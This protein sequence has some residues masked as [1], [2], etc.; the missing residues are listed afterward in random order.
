MD[1]GRNDDAPVRCTVEHLVLEGGVVCMKEVK[2]D[3]GKFLPPL[4][5]IP[6]E[7]A[8]EFVART[9]VDDM[10]GHL[11]PAKLWDRIRKSV[12]V[13]ECESLSKLVVLNC[14]KCMQAKDCFKSTAEAPL[15]KGNIP[16]S[17]FDHWH[18]DLWSCNAVEK[19]DK[20]FGNFQRLY[21]K[22]IWLLF[23]HVST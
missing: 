8:F 15:Q 16:T 11:Q 6:R 2:G 18:L 13:P 17:I 19:D 23:S 20:G 12:Y 5:V 21:Q 4:P 7:D 3:D 22:S 14:G 9:H 10:I 1:A